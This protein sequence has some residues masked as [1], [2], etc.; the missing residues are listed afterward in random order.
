[1]PGI[2]GIQ[3]TSAPEHENLVLIAYTLKPYLNVH[4]DVSSEASSSIH[5]GL[6]RLRRSCSVYACSERSDGS[7]HLRRTV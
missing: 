7:A 3:E 1:M 6:S 5:I 2:H 4:A